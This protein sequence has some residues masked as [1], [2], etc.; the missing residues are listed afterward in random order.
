MKKSILAIAALAIMAWG[1]SGSD[2]DMPSQ[3]KILL[4]GKDA[5]PTWQIPNFNEYEQYMTVE[6]SL[7]DTLQSY[8]SPA[9][10]LCAT[11]NDEVRGVSSPQNSNGKWRFVITVA[12]N[13]SGKDVHL[14]LGQV[15]R[16]RETNGRRQF[17]FS[18]FCGTRMKQLLKRNGLWLLAITIASS[19][20]STKAR[21]TFIEDK[22]YCNEKLLKL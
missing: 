6:V 9:D 17:L 8:A 11:I 21:V 3:P 5:R 14:L 18:H 13:E 12:S 22:V 1:C 2:D 10:L 7:Q 16:K 4:E 19:L 15:R 20:V